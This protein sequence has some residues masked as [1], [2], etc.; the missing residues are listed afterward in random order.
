MVRSMAR[1]LVT[2]GAGFIGSHLVESLLADGHVVRVLDDLSSGLIENLPPNVDL[3]QGDVSRQDVVRRA[4]EGI[5][6]CFHLAAIASVEHCRKDWLRS[7]TVNLGGTIAVF[8]ELRRARHQRRLP[9]VFASSA[10]IYGDTS[11]IPISEATPARPASAYAIDKLGCELHAAVA[12]RI[13]DLEAVGLRFFNVYGPRQAPNSA[14]SG[15]ISIFCRRLSEGMPIDIQGDGSQVRDFVYIDDAVA[16]LRAAMAVATPAPRVFNVCTGI[17]TSI[18]DVAKIIAQ[19]LGVR[20]QP[21]YVSSRIGDLRISSGD[22]RLA[23]DALRFAARVPL[24]QGLERTL[25]G[26]LSS[27]ARAGSSHASLSDAN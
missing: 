9:V 23:T 14:Y 19:I 18:I 25:A 4:V 26:S 21:R 22:P 11:Q 13:H 24:R 2:G 7:H 16:A 8:D 27:A 1:Y 12:S 15:V 5:D 17:G 3:I 10:A 20:F 6:G